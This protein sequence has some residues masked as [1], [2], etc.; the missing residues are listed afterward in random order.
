MAH[1]RTSSAFGAP[2]VGSAVVRFRLQGQASTLTLFPFE[3]FLVD[4][5]FSVLG[6]SRVKAINP[7][8]KP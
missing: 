4:L 2:C 8:P 7:K 1:V 3:E 5:R 6:P